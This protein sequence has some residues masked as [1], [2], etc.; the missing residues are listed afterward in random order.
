MPAEGLPKAGKTIGALSQAAASKP[1]ENLYPIE[2][3]RQN[4]KDYIVNLLLSCTNT[5]S[6]GKFTACSAEG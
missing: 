6:S 1:L 2:L 4:E 5:G 3:A